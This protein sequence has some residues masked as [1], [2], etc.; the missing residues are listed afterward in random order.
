MLTCH[1]FNRIKLENANITKIQGRIYLQNKLELFCANFYQ[2]IY[3]P[4]AF[5]DTSL[6]RL[7]EVFWYLFYLKFF[8]T[9]SLL[10][11]TNSVSAH[12]NIPAKVIT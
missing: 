4:L 7:F 12:Q 5:I 10:G 2:N 6:W 1:A 3:R 9:L 8:G 11:L